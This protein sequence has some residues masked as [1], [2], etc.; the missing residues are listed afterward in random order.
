MVMAVLNASSAPAAGAGNEEYS[1]FKLPFASTVA[2][3]IYEVQFVLLLH[4]TSPIVIAASFKALSAAFFPFSFPSDISPP[5]D[6]IV[7]VQVSAFLNAVVA[8]PASFLSPAF[9]SAAHTCKAVTMDVAF[10]VSVEFLDL[11]TYFK[12]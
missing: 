12:Y 5:V 9:G 11:S 1:I 2:L 3:I 8:T 4:F 7:I 10:E 6:E